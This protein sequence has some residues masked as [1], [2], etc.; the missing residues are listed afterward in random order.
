MRAKY[1]RLIR[2][3]IMSKCYP[4]RTERDPFG[5]YTTVL[6]FAQLREYQFQWAVYSDNKLVQRARERTALWNSTRNA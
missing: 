1:A 2:I 6:D 4:Y 5:G 3:G